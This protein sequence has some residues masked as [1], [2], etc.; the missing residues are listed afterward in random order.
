MP[1]VSGHELARM[2]RA[3]RALARV[4]ERAV[5][6][7]LV[8]LRIPDVNAPQAMMLHD[9]GDRMVRV[10]DLKRQSFHLGTNPAYNLDALCG[11]DMLE[12]IRDHDDRRVVMVRATPRG[13]AI[14]RVVADLFARRAAQAGR[15]GTIGAVAAETAD[16]VEALGADLTALIRYV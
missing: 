5:R 8:R 4:T 1:A 9:L 6:D 2:V 13:I 10:T 11:M 16:R 12:R 3:V 7:E 14:G 15:M